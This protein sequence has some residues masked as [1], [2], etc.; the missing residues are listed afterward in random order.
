MLDN[1]RPMSSTPTVLIAGCGFLGLEIARQF[2]HRGWRVFGLTR[3]A[4]SAR[5]AAN[6]TGIEPLVADL[7]DPGALRSAAKSSPHFHAVVHCAGTGGGSVDDYRRVYA[8][9][10]RHLAEVLAPDTLFFTSST[11]VYRQIDGTVVDETSLAG[12]GTAKAE[13]L[14]QAE[15]TVLGHGGLV[16]RL[17]GIYG[18]G[19][20]ALL[21]KFLHQQ[22]IL[23][24]GGGKWIN[25]I[26]RDDAA[27]AIVHLI[28]MPDRRAAL[29][30]VCD[31][32]PLTQHRIYE[33]LA[34]YF[35]R[36]IPPH[37]PRDTSRKRGWTDKRVSNARLLRTGWAPAY[38]SF[39]EAVRHDAR[40]TASFADTDQ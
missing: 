18:P 29:F 33:G 26:H 2:R 1:F 6:A 24:D 9:G 21:R 32:E 25:Q 10:S 15:Q 13:I 37:G 40:L 16:A 11:S 5:E 31:N 27:S 28:T 19:R 38:P 7:T 20:S 4:G 17:A 14:A 3:T 39:L 34:S 8:E 23:E 30:N 22:A 36:P 12:V 35:S